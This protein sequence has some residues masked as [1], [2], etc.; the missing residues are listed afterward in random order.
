MVLA[1]AVARLYCGAATAGKVPPPDPPPHLRLYA[2]CAACHPLASWHCG[3]P[4]P[5]SSTLQLPCN[6]LSAGPSVPPR[7]TAADSEP[8]CPPARYSVCPGSPFALDPSARP[9]WSDSAGHRPS[10][11]EAPPRG[12]VLKRRGWQRHSC[13]QAT[14]LA[15]PSGVPRG[16]ASLQDPSPLRGTLGSSIRSPAEGK[17]N[18]GFPD[19]KSVV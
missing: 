18:E 13:S 6:P 2:T 9:A 4:A 8:G 5:L 11:L 1:P 19:R 14:R 3:T 10:P 7:C 12:A 17:G 16:P 15:R